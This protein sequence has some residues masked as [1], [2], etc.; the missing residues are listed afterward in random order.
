MPTAVAEDA[1]P[2]QLSPCHRVPHIHL[3]PSLPLFPASHFTPCALLLSSC[4]RAAPAFP[5]RVRARWWRCPGLG[6]PGT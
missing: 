2:V 1:R 4:L 6:G 3:P 5:P